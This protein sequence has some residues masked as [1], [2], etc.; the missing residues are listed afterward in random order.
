MVA[1]AVG[2]SVAGVVSSLAFMKLDV[3]TRQLVQV[4]ERALRHLEEKRVL[5]G[6]DEVTELVKTSHQE[7][8]S[9]LD[10]YRVIIQGLQLSVA[11]LF[12]LAAIYSLV[13]T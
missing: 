13:S 4:A 3:R 12:A 11:G 2:V 8:R 5:E 7:R 6:L 1:I 10:S 9:P